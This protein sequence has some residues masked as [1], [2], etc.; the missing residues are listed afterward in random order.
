MSHLFL[1]DVHIGAFEDDLEKIVRQDLVKLLNYSASRGMQIHILGDLFDYWMEYPSWKPSVGKEILE[2][3]KQYSE[4]VAPINFITGN[5]DNWTSGYFEELGF[6]V[7]GEFLDLTIQ[8][9]RLFLHHGDGLND[10]SYNLPRPF[11]HRVLRNKMFVKLYQSLLPPRSGIRLMK[12]FSDYSKR[13]A[14]CDPSV[15]DKWAEQFLS[16]SDYDYV[17]CGHDHQPRVLSFK[18]GKYINLGTFFEDRTVAIYNNS[19]LELV[20]WDAAHGTLH[21]FEHRYKKQLVYE[22]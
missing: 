2:I 15:L 9:K 20:V 19:E 14:Y 13:R 1:S 11:M 16:D 12:A 3:F 22:Q 6:N 10:S 18:D 21:P 8:S 17:L 4:G 5:H 7:S